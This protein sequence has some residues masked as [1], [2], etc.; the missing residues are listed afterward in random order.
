M[1]NK[2]HIAFDL[3]GTLIDSIPLMRLSWENVNS[4][5]NLCIGW[6]SYS[7]NIGLPFQE[8][9]KN[10]NIEDLEKEVRDLYFNFNNSNIHEIKPMKGLHDC[11]SWLESENIDWSIITSKP[12]LTTKPIL[13][14]FNLKPRVVITSTDVKNGKPNPE[15][16]D[17]LIKKIDNKTV[18][19][20][21]YV[22][23]TNID[24][25]FSINSNFEFIEFISEH[26]RDNLLKSKLILNNRHIVSDL[27]KIQFYV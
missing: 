24:H 17:L 21:Y 6:E 3:D 20:I 9:C 19:K 10:L 27:A 8:I 4:K 12:G 16:S 26:D 18:K 22:G 25:L 2:I 13:K 23:D 15:S 14:R 7:R 11:I 1:H 5:L